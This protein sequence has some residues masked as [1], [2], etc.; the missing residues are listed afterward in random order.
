MESFNLEKKIVVSIVIAGIALSM[1]Q[2]IYNRSIWLDEAMLSLNIIHRSHLELLKPLD[3]NQAAPILFL[4]IEKIFSQLIPNSDFGLRIFPLIC[5]LLSLF[6]F[7]KIVRALH[8]NYYTIIFSLSLFVFN[9]TLIYYSSEVKQYM[10]DV[11]ILT[12]FY[13]LMLR[14]NKNEKYKYYSLVIFGVIGIFLSNVTPIIL[15]TC[16]MYLLVD[17]YQNN[18]KSFPYLI[19]VSIIWSV[20]FLVYYILF[21]YNYPSLGTLQKFFSERNSFMPTYPFSI[22]FYNFFVWKW[23]MVFYSLFT[24]ESISGALLSI[25]AFLGI[26]TLIRKKETGAVILITAPLV[27]HLLLSALKLYPV[28]KRTILYTLPCII[29]S[30]SFGFNYLTNML[31]TDLKIERFRLLAIFITLGLP[32]YFFKEGFPA[33]TWEIKKS[34]DFVNKN[35]LENDKICLNDVSNVIFTYYRDIYF[36]KINSDKIII[37]DHANLS[38]AKLI[39]PEFLKYSGGLNLLKGRVWFLFADMTNEHIRKNFVINYCAMKGKKIVKEFH[40]TGSEVYLFD[41][42]N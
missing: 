18:R 35:M 37:D 14:E 24:F 16:G 19:A 36:I 4:Q 30:C 42:G 39:D 1:V 31:F 41:L 29:T 9:A 23:R 3:Y 38:D 13:Y 6:F 8:Q 12:G 25:L 28:E 26:L 17:I 33:K 15:F 22:D 27:L 20:V 7:Y 32:F 40:T 34:I 10:T 21:I 5:F 2:F 11:M